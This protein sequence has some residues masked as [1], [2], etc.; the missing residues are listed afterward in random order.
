MAYLVATFPPENRPRTMAGLEKFGWVITE[1]LKR[2][3]FERGLRHWHF[4]GDKSK[5]W[6]PHLNFLMDRGFINPEDLDAIKKEICEE[7]GLGQVVLNYAYSRA[8]GKRF[9]WIKYVLRATFLY[10]GWDFKMAEELYNFRNSAAWGQWEEGRPLKTKKLEELRLARVAAGYFVDKWALPEKEKKLAY[11]KKVEA[12]LC[13]TCGKKLEGGRV[14]SVDFFTDEK[15]RGWE[16]IW[17]NVWQL[18]GPP[19][20]VL[21]YRLLLDY[22][23]TK[24]EAAPFEVEGGE[25][26]GA[27]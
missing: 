14:V 2:R 18:K 13:P 24:K 5:V 27:L 6:N 10:Q 4:F 11:F 15:N 20:N 19:E 17:E 25:L 3:G 1:I 12:G 22:S 26:G 8:F 16:K 7:L 9:H 21:L 23:R